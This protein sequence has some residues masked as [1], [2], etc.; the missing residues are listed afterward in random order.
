VAQRLPRCDR[1]LSSGGLLAHRVVKPSRL[2]TNVT[3]RNRA[4]LQRCRQ[5]RRIRAGFSRCGIPIDKERSFPIK[6]FEPFSCPDGLK[7]PRT[8][9]FQLSLSGLQYSLN[10]SEH[11]RVLYVVYLPP[12]V[13]H[14]VALP[15]LSRGARV[16]TVS[17][18]YLGHLAESAFSF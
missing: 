1:T 12:G 10:R 18:R 15:E 4:S 16:V 13:Y 7:T 11:P 9:P 6:S 14:P 8:P 17:V 3:I 2:V 5:R